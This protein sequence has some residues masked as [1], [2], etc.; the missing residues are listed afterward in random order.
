MSQVD[1]ID[2]I[3]SEVCLDSRIPDGIFKLDENVHVEAL[4]ELFVDKWGLTLENAVELTNAMLEGRFPERQAYNKDGILVT[5]P[6]PKHKAKALAKGTHFDKNPNPQPQQSPDPNSQMPANQTEPEPEPPKGAPVFP[7][8]E[9]GTQEPGT[10]VSV[11]PTSI[12]QG[13]Q[14]LAIEPPAGSEPPA[15][16]PTPPSATT[17]PP[18]T[19][20]QIAAEKEVVKQMIQS[21]D[22]AITSISH[23]NISE[24]CVWELAVLKEHAITNGF[25]EAID[26]FNRYIK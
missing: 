17:T 24:K 8:Q 26:F 6:T 11:G 12:R 23:P 25:S 9:P 4:R 21:D 10:Q 13:N 15:S 20:E 16:S 5:F 1:V 3:L 2:R 22:T 18:E 14:T 7:A 19:P